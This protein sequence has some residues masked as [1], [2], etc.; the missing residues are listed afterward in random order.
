MFA[1]ILLRREGVIISRKKI[2][3]CNEDIV[4]KA[5]WSGGGAAG[6]L[7]SATERRLLVLALPNQRS[8][9]A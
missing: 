7:L 4:K 9:A 3:R 5:P 1:A 2:Q 8:R 6:G